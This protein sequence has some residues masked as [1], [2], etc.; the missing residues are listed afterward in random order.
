MTPAHWF[1]RL[2]ST[3]MGSLELFRWAYEH[4]TPRKSLFQHHLNQWAEDLR[5]IPDQTTRQQIW[6]D[7]SA[8]LET[9]WDGDP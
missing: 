7:V 8:G 6:S 4:A 5:F 2:M 3:E 1:F 9:W